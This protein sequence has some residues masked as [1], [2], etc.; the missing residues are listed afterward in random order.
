[1]QV[2]NRP[3]HPLLGSSTLDILINDSFFS[4]ID[5]NTSS[6]LNRNITMK[7]IFG[8]ISV[9]LF[10]SSASAEHQIGGGFYNLGD[11]DISFTGLAGV[12]SNKFNDNFAADVAIAIGGS[13]N[14]EGID[15]DV[16][17]GLAAKL[18]GG[19]TSGDMFL[20]VSAGYATFDLDVSFEGLKESTDGN[21]AL[22][23]VGID[24]SVSDKTTINVDYSRGFGDLEDSNL[25]MGVLKYR[26]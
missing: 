16:N 12:Y 22:A 20:Y 17:N 4:R 6:K 26:F 15:A 9:L 24:F 14:Y 11:G 10:A 3:W 7:K 21:G 13:D 18:K 5:Y 23:G 25:F 8:L 2:K 1:M 19:I